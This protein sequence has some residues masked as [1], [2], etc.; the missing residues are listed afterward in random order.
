MGSQRVGHNW[1]TELNWSEVATQG[2]SFWVCP[3][4]HPQV[5]CFFLL[6]N[7]LPALL[8]SVLVEI[9]FCRPEGL[10]LL[11]L[12]TGLVARIWCFHCC[13]LSSVSGI[14]VCWSSTSSHWRLRPPKIRAKEESKRASYIKLLDSL[15]LKV[16]VNRGGTGSEPCPS[17]QGYQ[18]GLAN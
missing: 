14:S 4:V 3:C 8:L 10:G 18:G 15:I 6:I 1:A 13:D 17:K 16:R 9:L 2:L 7:T 12:T 5:L 11:S